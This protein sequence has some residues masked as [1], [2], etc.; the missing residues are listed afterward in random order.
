MGFNWLSYFSILGNPAL[1][2]YIENIPNGI[3]SPVNDQY[4]NWITGYSQLMVNVGK[5]MGTLVS[6]LPPG[7]VALFELG[8]ALTLLGAIISMIIR[9]L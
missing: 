5:M 4:N 7:I 2:D 1:A 9:L 3:W 6:S 8:I